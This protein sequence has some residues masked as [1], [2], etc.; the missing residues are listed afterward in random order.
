M[1]MSGGALHLLCALCQ[2]VTQEAHIQS[3]ISLL[4]CAAEMLRHL[5]VHPLDQLGHAGV[6]TGHS[7]LAAAD[8]PGDDAG[9]DVL[10][11]VLLAGT[12][13][14]PASVA[15]AGVHTVFSSSTGE[16]AVQAEPA[17]E[18]GLLQPVLARPVR[19]HRQVDLLHDVLEPSAVELVLAV[20][21][22]HAGRVVEALILFRE[23]QRIDVLLQLD[24][25][26]QEEKGHVVAQVAAVEALMTLHVRHA[27]LLVRENLLLVLCVPVSEADCQLVLVLTVN[28][29]TKF[30]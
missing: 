2:S 4:S 3:P 7:V 6:D 24:G 1:I 16:R 21:G 23:A 29:I 15:P 20:A 19:H 28:D 18:T 27:V 22:G 8:A 5:H 11:G 9:L 12:G 17:A 10:V 26:L 25:L 14:R 13:E 30:T